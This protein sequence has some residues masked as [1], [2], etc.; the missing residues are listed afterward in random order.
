[1]AAHLQTQCPEV[2]IPNEVSQRLTT[3]PRLNKL[4]KG[5]KR[6]VIQMFV[7]VS[8][9]PG[10]LNLKDVG[11]QYFSLTSLNTGSLQQL[12]NRHSS[13]IAASKSA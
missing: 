6:C 3:A 11:E 7:A 4:S 2:T 10:A 9:Q 13:A 12:A 5:V 1:V 8:E